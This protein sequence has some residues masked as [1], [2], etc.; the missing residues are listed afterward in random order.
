MLGHPMPAADLSV[1]RTSLPTVRQLTDGLDIVLVEDLL[2][3]RATI[4]RLEECIRLA[5]SHVDDPVDWL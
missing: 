2:A 3:R 1:S 4:T 5:A